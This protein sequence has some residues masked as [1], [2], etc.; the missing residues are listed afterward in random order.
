MSDP[1]A[2]S[3]LQKTIMIKNM[4]VLHIISLKVSD[5]AAPLEK[6][7]GTLVSHGTPVEKHRI[8]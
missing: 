1:K 4:D 6:R 3:E 5:L 7:Y 2:S 8:R